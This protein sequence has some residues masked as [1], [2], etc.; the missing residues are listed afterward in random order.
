MIAE[1]TRALYK[2]P[3]L[4]ALLRTWRGKLILLVVASQLLLPLHY[5]LARYDYHDERF[6]WR[7]FSPIRMTT[8]TPE[9]TVDGKPFALG[10]E[11]HEFWIEAA[12]RGRL[13]VVEAMGQ[14]LCHEHPGAAVTITLRCTYLDRE[15]P[16]L[17]GG[18]NLCDAPG[19]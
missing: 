15:Q 12:R 16:V 8:C 9:A 3:H 4:G 19:I 17:F 5:Y 13:G 11:F 7:M 1:I 2:I 6:A 10:G 14:R 18:F